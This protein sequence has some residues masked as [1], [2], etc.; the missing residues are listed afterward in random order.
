MPETYIMIPARMESSRFP[1]KPFAKINNKEMLIRVLDKCK[2]EFKLFAV[3]NSPELV[4]LVKKYGYKEILIKDACSTGTD[5]IAKA[6]KKLNLNDEDIIIN[7]Q[8]DEPLINI[9]MIRKIIQAKIKN[10]NKIINA[11]SSI[12]SQDEFLSKSVIKMVFDK[13]SNLLFASRSPI[14]SKKGNYDFKNKYK[15]TCIYAFSAKQLYDFSKTERGFLEKSEDIEII[16]FLENKLYDVLIID[17][18]KNDL[19]AVDYPSDIEIIEKILKK[20]SK[21]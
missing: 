15:Q 3:V 21:K 1:K 6:V 9:G 8:G 19:H 18:G 10:P 11:V 17:L 14:P 20:N 4:N 13:F 16:R 7:V 5:R 2:S 12:N